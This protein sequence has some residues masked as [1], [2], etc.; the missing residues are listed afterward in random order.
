M[1]KFLK[2][3]LKWEL[4]TLILS[5]TVYFLSGLGPIVSVIIG[6]AIGALVFFPIDKKIFEGKD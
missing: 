3:L 4:G 1:K 2:Y 6:N 5:P